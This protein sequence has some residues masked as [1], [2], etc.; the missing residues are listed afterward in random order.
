MQTIPS[1]SPVIMVADKT[2]TTQFNNDPAAIRLI[3]IE[4][5]F[6]LNKATPQPV[7]FVVISAIDCNPD[8]YFF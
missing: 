3:A 5:V 6:T 4:F 8:L 7:G 1:S 2:S